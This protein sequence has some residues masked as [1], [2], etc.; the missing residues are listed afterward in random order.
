MSSMIRVDVLMGLPADTQLYKPQVVAG[1]WLRTPGLNELIINDFAAQRLHL[2]VGDKVTVHTNATDTNQALQAYWTIIGIVHDVDEV[3]G[4]ANPEGRQGWAFTTLTNLNLTLRHED[5]DMAER[6]WLQARN[7]SPQ[8]L[9][10]LGTRVQAALSQYDGAYYQ[11]WEQVH[12]A[13][14]GSF[15][16]V[17][18]LFSIA[19]LLVA[20]IGLL[21]LSHTLAASVLERRLEIGILRSLGA[22]SWRV[23]TVFFVEAMALAMIAW[24]VGIVLGI[25]GAYAILNLFSIYFGPVDISL[26]PLAILI[27]FLLIIV[28]VILASFGPS[29]SASRVRIRGI[30]RYE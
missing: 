20:V 24:G 10:V 11:P 9:Q 8:A 5:A 18:L 3:S 13:E 4:S 19:A 27:T 12:A 17:Y 21:S 28:V 25:P 14:T 2:H 29:L 30:L 23:G 1:H 16:I 7:H 15:S 26:Q 22:T 6:L